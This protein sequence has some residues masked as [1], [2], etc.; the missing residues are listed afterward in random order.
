VHRQHVRKK[1][2][3]FDNFLERFDDQVEEI[4]LVHPLGLCPHIDQMVFAF[5]KFAAKFFDLGLRVTL[6]LHSMMKDAVFPG[7]SGVVAAGVHAAVSA[8]GTQGRNRR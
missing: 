5:L 7:K 4:F 8:C 3:N 2:T 1:F 6:A